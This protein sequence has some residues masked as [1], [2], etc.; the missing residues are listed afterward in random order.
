VALVV[1]ADA[2][3]D[4]EFDAMDLGAVALSWGLDVPAKASHCVLQDYG[5]TSFDIAAIVEAFHNAFGG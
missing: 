3:S 1:D 2:D 4:T 5:V